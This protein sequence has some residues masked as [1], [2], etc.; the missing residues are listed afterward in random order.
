MM[1]FKNIVFQNTFYLSLVQI[2]NIFLPLLTVPYLARILGVSQFGVY[3][4]AQSI[5]VF[6]L[7]L[8]D[9]GF[10]L[11]ATQQIAKLRG[12]KEQISLIFWSTQ[13]AKLLLLIPAL[14]SLLILVFFFNSFYEIRWAVLAS[15]PILLGSILFPQW[16]FQGIEKMMWIAVF[17]F[18]ARLITIPLIFIFVHD[19]QDV[20]LAIAIQTAAGIFSGIASIILIFQ[21]KLIVWMRPRWGQ[22]MFTLKDGWHIFIS[23]VATT[24][25]TAANPALVGIFSNSFQVGLFGAADKIKSASQ[26]LVSP[27]GTA[28]YPRIN[29]LMTES[30]QSGIGLAQKALLVQGGI[31]LV[32]ALI[33]FIFAPEIIT[34]LMGSQFDD[35]VS[36]L[37]ILSFVPFLT[38]LSNVF[39][40]QLMLPLGRKKAFSVIVGITTLINLGLVSVLAYIYGAVGAAIANFFAELIVTLL[41]LF[42]LLRIDINPFKR[43]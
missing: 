42:Y 2:A 3:I 17:N 37:R 14:I 29:V 7:M 19:A 35:A 32:I 40:V 24:L 18:I 28:V 22:I 12:Q 13:A 5:C 33:S 26:S 8:V 15:T 4:L 34:I 16:F 25:Y 6:G 11:T 39:G 38:A 21:L 31:T 36:I 43:I 9:Y 1:I 23:G 41:M 30:S 27:I 10:N 20:V